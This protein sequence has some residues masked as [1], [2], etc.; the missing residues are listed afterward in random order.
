MPSVKT[1]RRETVLENP[2][3]SVF[4]G[5]SILGRG[6][7]LEIEYLEWKLIP[8]E[9]DSPEHPLESFLDPQSF[10]QGK[11]P[12]GGWLCSSLGMDTSG[13][14]SF[15]WWGQRSANSRWATVS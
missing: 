9:T 8:L 11:L 5:R 1:G 14:V 7:H 12:K 15:S 10:D 6:V 4:S 2:L 3:L 13:T